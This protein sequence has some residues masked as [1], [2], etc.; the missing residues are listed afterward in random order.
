[1]ATGR[2]NKRL[3]LTGASLRPPRG[4]SFVGG[5]IGIVVTSHGGTGRER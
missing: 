2:P 3:Q 4:H 1:M 5:V